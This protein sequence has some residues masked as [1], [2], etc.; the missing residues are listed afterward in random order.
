M[1]PLPRSSAAASGSFAYWSCQLLGWTIYGLSQVYNTVLTLDVPLG[2]AVSEIALLNAVAIGL[3]HGLRH[4]MR[5]RA[6][7]TLRMP[8]LLPR[9][10]AASIVLGLLQAAIMHFM[11][12]APMWELD[13]VEDAAV[14]AALPEFLGNPAVLRIM[15]WSVAFLVWIAMYLSVT[16][17]RDR[18]AAELRQSELTRALQLSELRLLKSQLNPHFL[19][20]SL[21][22]VRALISEDPATAQN[23]VTRLART[24]RYTLSAGQEELVTLERELEIVED[25]LALESLRFGERLRI[26]RDID[27]RALHV[28]IP[29]ML[30][31]TVV[32]NAI[33][34]G[35]AELPGGGVLRVCAAMRE[36]GLH[37][38]VQNPRP[39]VGMTAA[40]GQGVGLHN[41][42]ERLRLLFGER[43]RFELDLSRADLASARI[44]VPAIS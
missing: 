1:H 43:A 20:N 12:V 23:A 39:V 24:L 42:A 10:L 32:E 38:D 35:I 18:H 33:K 2:R 19:F 13:R 25:Y 27:P 14:L 7:P 44:C 4:F 36:D 16:S 8:A 37:V 22:T 9:V 11:A 31:Q 6:W 21:N 26:D 34:H 29:A 41:A 3:T 40:N 30:L 17:L 5:R 15:N 28:R